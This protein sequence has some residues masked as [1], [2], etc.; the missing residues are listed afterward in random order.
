MVRRKRISRDSLNENDPPEKF[1]A[2]KERSSYMT[3]WIQGAE[4]ILNDVQAS[5][6]E[7]PLLVE[8]IKTLEAALKG[9]R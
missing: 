9:T 2:H 3:G 1:I 5:I 8:K 7:E 6:N 4:Y